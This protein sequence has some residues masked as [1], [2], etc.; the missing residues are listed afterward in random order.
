MTT[1]NQN[2]FELFKSTC[3]NFYTESDSGDW[4][5]VANSSI[6]GGRIGEDFSDR[7]D[8]RLATIWLA[9]GEKPKGWKILERNRLSISID[10]KQ[11][12]PATLWIEDVCKHF[13]SIEK[14]LKP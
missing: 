13:P 12:Y 5:I 11:G 10:C 9:T 7:N 4:Y 14:D 6:G 8:A 2:T 3:P 1:E